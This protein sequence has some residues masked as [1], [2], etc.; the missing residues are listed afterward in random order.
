MTGNAQTVGGELRAVRE[1]LGWALEDVAASLRIRA[2]YLL[3]IEEGR[4]GDLPGTTYA[5]G[6]V[7]TYAASLGLDPDETVQ[8]FKTEAGASHHQQELHFPAPVPERGVPAGAVVL[9]GAVIA[10]AGYIGWYKL[11]ANHPVPDAVQEVPEHLAPLARKEETKTPLAS[12]PNASAT[13]QAQSSAPP[14]ASSASPAPVSGPQASHPTQTPSNGPTGTQA[15]TADTSAPSQPAEHQTSERRTLERAA[16][17]SIPSSSGMPAASSQPSFP[18]AQTVPPPVPDAVKPAA[19]AEDKTLRGIVLKASA[20]AWMQ[21][22]SQN[23]TILLNKVLHAG[24]SW[25]VPEAQAGQGPLLLTTGNAGGTQVVVDGHDLPPLGNNGAVRRNVP[26]EAEA[27]QK[28]APS[29]IPDQSRSSVGSSVGSS[30]RSSVSPE[31]AHD[32]SSTV[33]SPAPRT[34]DQDNSAD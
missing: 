30:G 23:G 32:R 17:A 11:S 27:L 12:Q 5:M 21:V 20:D 26:L 22:K 14:S 24:E 13:S 28:A 3:A 1:H 29:A 31:P 2:P 10:V 15:E 19:P 18:T 7:R 16:D 6:F 9:L 25:A 34:E 8:R 33:S 4:M